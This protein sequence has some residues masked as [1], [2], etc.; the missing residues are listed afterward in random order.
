MGSELIDTACLSS[1]KGPPPGVVLHGALKGMA[2]AGMVYLKKVLA[3]IC[4]ALGWLFSI[5]YVILCSAVMSFQLEI[6]GRFVLKGS[7][8]TELWKGEARECRLMTRLRLWKGW[9]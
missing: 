8:E 7:A 2:L 1:R 5:P 4:L 3:R 6:Q 9:L